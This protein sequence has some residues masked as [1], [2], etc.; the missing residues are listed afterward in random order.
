M[1]ESSRFLMMLRKIAITTAL[2][3]LAMML[4]VGCGSGERRGGGDDD[5]DDSAADDD[6]TAGD[7][8]DTTGDDDDTTGDDDDTTGD[9]DDTTGDDDDTTGGGGS[10]IPM[11]TAVDLCEQPSPDPGGPTC[12]SPDFFVQF[13]IFVSDSDGDLQNPTI[14]LA[15]QGGSPQAQT[16]NGDLGAGGGVGLQVCSTWP[17]GQ[18]ISYS[19]SIEDAS[20]N[21]SQDF[22][23][24]WSV[25]ASTGMSDC[26]E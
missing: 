6:D 3:T 22:P 8:D 15:L 11:V 4:S 23:G 24:T 12:T 19:V 18:D 21:R 26:T 9:D 10:G 5:D 25:P 20:G 17:R 16:L 13:N 7:D 2:L 14:Y 1:S